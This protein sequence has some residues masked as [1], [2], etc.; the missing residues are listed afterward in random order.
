MGFNLIVPPIPA[1]APEPLDL[2]NSK[3]ALILK[4]C[5]AK[6]CN[7]RMLY[8]AKNPARQA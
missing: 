6:H 2:S 3:S 8:L 5:V 1:N 4:T 7:L